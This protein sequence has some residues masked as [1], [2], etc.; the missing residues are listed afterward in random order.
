LLV[1]GRVLCGHP[2][3]SSAC[4]IRGSLFACCGWVDTSAS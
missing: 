3:C 2:P 1:D 4:G